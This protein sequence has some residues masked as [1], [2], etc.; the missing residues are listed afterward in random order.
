[1]IQQVLAEILVKRLLRTI[2]GIITRPR[3]PIALVKAKGHGLAFGGAFGVLGRAW[4]GWVEKGLVALHADEGFGT[5]CELCGHGCCV[6]GTGEVGGGDVPRELRGRHL[7]T[8][9]MLPE[10]AGSAMVGEQKRGVLL[11][12]EENY[13][14]TTVD[15]SRRAVGG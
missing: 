9:L 5:A 11:S 7:T 4:V 8:T 1:M 14:S 12:T 15:Q 3:R 2:D 13:T 6:G 10:S